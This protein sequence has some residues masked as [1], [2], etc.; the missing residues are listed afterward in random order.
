D[1]TALVWDLTPAHGRPGRARETPDAKTLALWWDDL[2]SAKARRAY[3]ALWRFA[4]LPEATAVA[5]FRKHLRPAE[6]ANSE[7]VRKHIED[8]DNDTCA[9]REKAQQALE[10]LGHAAAAEVRQALEKGP[11]LEARRRLEKLLAKAGRLPSSPEALR[12][13]RALQV[14]EGLDSKEAR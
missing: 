11:P 7:V 12:A 6:S 14:L 13:V 8:L 2:G 9:V 1:G 5:F 4:D 3:L 10:E